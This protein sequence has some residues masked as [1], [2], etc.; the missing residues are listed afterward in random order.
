MVV[1]DEDFQVE[2]RLKE[3]LLKETG[4]IGCPWLRKDLKNRTD[5]K[6]TTETKRN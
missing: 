3:T 4:K 6:Y 1:Q 2:F 5:I